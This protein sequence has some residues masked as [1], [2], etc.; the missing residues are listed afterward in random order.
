MIVDGYVAET[1]IDYAKHGLALLRRDFREGPHDVLGEHRAVVCRSTEPI[2]LM[3]DGE[4]MTGERLERFE[5]RKCEV[6]FLATS[7]HRLA[8]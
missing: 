1:A 6:E 2:E 5:I 4:R 8:S 7:A 3:I